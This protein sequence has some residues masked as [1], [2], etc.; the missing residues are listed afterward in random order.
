VGPAGEYSS[1]PL[2]GNGMNLKFDTNQKAESER[3]DAMKQS[4]TVIVV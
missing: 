3:S 2:R 1:V 4:Q